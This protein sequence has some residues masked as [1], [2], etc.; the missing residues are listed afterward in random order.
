MANI[1]NF[2]LHSLVNN[3]NFNFINNLTDTGNIDD[4]NSDDFTDSPYTHSTFNTSYVDTPTLITQI[5]KTDCISVMALNI[6]SL[7][8][9]Y[10]SLRELVMELGAANC[11][12]EIIC[13]QEIWTVVG[14]DLFPLPGYQPIVFKTRSSGQGGGSAFTSGQG[15]L[16]KFA[17]PAPSL[18]TNC[19][20]PSL[21][22]ALYTQAKK[23]P[24]V[25][26]I[27]QTLNTQH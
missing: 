14:A 16:S 19:L 4:D 7:S 2:D 22:N 3:P 1:N 10:G 5:Q 24:L 9:K 8:A 21:L 11:Y 13:L 12:P 27:G 20:N 6:Q 26:S 17:K 15:S 18:L 25:Q 23:L